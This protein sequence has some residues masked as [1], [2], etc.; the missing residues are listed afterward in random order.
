MNEL[1]DIKSIKP[2]I[3]EINNFL[4]EEKN[5]SLSV[6]RLDKIHP[7]VSGNKLYKLHFFLEKALASSKRIL[8]FGGAYSN[9]LSATAFACHANKIS[10][11]GIVRGEKPAMLSHTLAYCLS[12]GMELIFLSREKY[13]RKDEPYFED[14]LLEKYPDYIIIPEGGFAHDGMKGAA[15][16]PALYKSDDYTH[17]CC[18]VGTATTLAG[19]ISSSEKENITGF[20][21]L[22]NFNDLEERL[23]ILLNCPTKNYSIISNYHFGG[24]AKRNEELINF[25]NRFYN[26]TGIPTDFVY[27]GKMLYG[28]IDL[29]NKNYFENGSK[30]L[31][32]HTG[33]LQGNLSLPANTLNF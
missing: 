17:I 3:T 2:A 14:N 20:S 6:L 21:V 23:K 31:C 13:F 28:T 22:K 27:T 1:P 18:A 12:L 7:Q 29:I 25:M 32:I 26:E 24:Y 19:L 8:T 10:C 5:I 15:L 16:I 33:G 4:T 9:H 30:I 11:I